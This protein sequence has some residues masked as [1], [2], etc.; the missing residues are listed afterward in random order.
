MRALIA[1][2]LLTGLAAQTQAIAQ[3]PQ[4]APTPGPAAYDRTAIVIGLGAI[5]GVVAFNAVTLGVIALPGGAALAGAAVVPAEA[6][7]AINRVYAVTTAVAGAWAADYLSPSTSVTGRLVTAGVGAVAGITAFNA[8]TAP[9]G[10]L[11]WSGVIADPIP[12][13]TMLGSRLLAAGTAGAGAVGATW[14]YG[15]ISGR[16]VDMGYALTL[17]GG[18]VA[19]VALGNVLSMGTLGAPPYYIGAGLTQAGGAIATVSEATASRIWAV[20][21]GVVGALAADY[22]YR[23]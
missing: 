3:V 10:A 5:A 16:P 8:L 14:L 6:V 13:A 11:P 4:A 18:A 2:V 23:K 19:G 21:T 12:T 22:W 9:L 15:K 20:G 7:V 1:G 17:A